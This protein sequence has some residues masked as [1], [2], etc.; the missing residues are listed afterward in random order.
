[1]CGKPSKMS[2]TTPPQSV[3]VPLL[4]YPP[5]LGRIRLLPRADSPGSEKH[6]SL[7]NT[8]VRFKPDTKKCHTIVCQ[9]MTTVHVL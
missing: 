3:V 7:E 2:A 6:A 8:L 5:L 1:M 9:F 4:D